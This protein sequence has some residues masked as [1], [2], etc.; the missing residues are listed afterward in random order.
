MLS[1]KH[2]TNIREFVD[3]VIRN[4]GDA[5]FIRTLNTPAGNTMQYHIE[6]YSTGVLYLFYYDPKN[7]M[8]IPKQLLRLTNVDDSSAQ[9]IIDA[10]EGD[11][12]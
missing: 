6:V 9:L 11:Y 5:G 12:L 3:K 8:K 7:I 4:P 1:E 2:K 10:I